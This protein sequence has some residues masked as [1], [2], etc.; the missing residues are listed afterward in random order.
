MDPLGPSARG[1]H[2][3]AGMKT[4]HGILALFLGLGLGYGCGD[5]D[6]DGDLIDGVSD[7]RISSA[8]NDYCSQA[9]DCDDEV[10]YDDCVSDCES[11]MMDCMADEQEQAVEELEGC[12]EESC[13]DFGVCTIGA[14]LQCTFGI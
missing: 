3:T 6:G 4:H 8:C 10:D 12:A 11:S 13:D 9:Q 7:I 2:T 5:G 1:V 14:G